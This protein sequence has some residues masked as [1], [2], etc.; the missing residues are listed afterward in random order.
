MNSRGERSPFAREYDTVDLESSKNLYTTVDDGGGGRGI[1]VRENRNKLLRYG[2]TAV[3]GVVGLL[4]IA[5]FLIFVIR[6]LMRPRERRV[7]AD[8]LVV[9]AVVWTGDSERPWAEA[10]SVIGGRIVDVGTTKQIL[11]KYRVNEKTGN[12]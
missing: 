8:M 6:S 7:V 2:V 4:V 10:F 11:D 5:I 1:L 9:D 12:D 3:L